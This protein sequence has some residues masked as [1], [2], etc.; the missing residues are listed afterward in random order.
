MRQ[1]LSDVK[2]Q[3]DA[4]L[5]TYT[6]RW[7]GYVPESFRVSEEEIQE[8]VNALDQQLYKDLAEAA[9][10]IRFIMNNRNVRVID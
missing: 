2:A 3:G 8:A 9:E 7:D 10:N 4:A 5:R 1:V 6:E